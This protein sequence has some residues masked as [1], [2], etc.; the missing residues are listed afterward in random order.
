MSYLAEMLNLAIV[1]CDEV[2]ARNIA[3]VIIAQ[4]F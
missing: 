3:R 2:K 4:S 1:M